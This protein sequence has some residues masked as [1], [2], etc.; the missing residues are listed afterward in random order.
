M[1]TFGKCYPQLILKHLLHWQL[2]I[3]IWSLL[4]A[5]LSFMTMSRGI[6]IA[7]HTVKEWSVHVIIHNKGEARKAM[8][9]LAI[10]EIHPR[11]K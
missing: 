6:G 2:S 5:W 1:H 3:C 10:L 4:K 11:E 8:D 9:S 7:I